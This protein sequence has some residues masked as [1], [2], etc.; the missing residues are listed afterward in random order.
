MIKKELFGKLSDGRD[1]YA[2]T[3]SNNTIVSVRIINYGGIVVNLWVED[4]NGK[5]ADV[6]CGFDDIDSYIKAGGYY[7]AIVGRTCNRIA[8]CKYSLDGVE[9]TLFANDGNNSLHGGEVG[10]NEKIWTVVEKDDT[11]EPEIEMTYVSPDMEENY[12]GTLT[13]KVIYSLTSDGGLSIRYEATTDKRTI[14]NLTNHS[15]FNLAGYDSGKI[16]G[17]IMWIDADQINEIDNELIP[18]GK[19]LPVEGTVYD[20]RTPK[21]IG[22]D[23]NDPSLSKQNGGYDNNYIIND[24]DPKK[25][26]LAASLREPASGRRM[27]VWTNQPCVQIYTTNSV[28]E[29]AIPFKNFVKPIL[30]CAVCFETQKMPDS[31]NHKEFTDITLAPGEV[32]DY[33]TVYKFSN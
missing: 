13:V 14:V 11:T 7:G 33:T 18:T 30:N 25:V 17:Q 2:Y 6:V 24:N 26:K 31:I 32:Y 27:E 9:Y 21:P 19:F 10:F 5:A 15:Y 4:K 28:D 29:D 1:V 8:N 12:P 23:F 22:C 3:L 16:N 20:F